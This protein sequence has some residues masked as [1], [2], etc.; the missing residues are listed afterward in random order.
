MAENIFVF[1][2][3]LGTCSPSYCSEVHVVQLLVLIA[4]AGM[5]FLHA[6]RWWVMARLGRVGG[7]VRNSFIVMRSLGAH[8]AWSLTIQ[9][10]CL[11]MVCS[12]HAAGRD[13]APPKRGGAACS[14]RAEGVACGHWQTNGPPFPN[15]ILL[16]LLIKPSPTLLFVHFSLERTPTSDWTNPPSG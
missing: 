13:P 14:C 7:S 12:S 6:V 3:W 1:L 16:G 2:P 9:G 8:S 15:R 4:A 5:G 11:H 10:S